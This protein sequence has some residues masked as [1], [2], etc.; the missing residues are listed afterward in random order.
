M[1]VSEWLN[2]NRPALARTAGWCAFASSAAIVI[3]IAP[4]QILLGVSLAALLLSRE[5]LRL[6]PIQLPLGLFLLG[7]LVAVALS[8]NPLA[9]F[10]QIKK[11]YVF[12]QLLVAFTLLQGAKIARWLVL[13]WAGCGAASALL[14]VFQF[15]WKL[16]YIHVHSEEFY[17]GYLSRRITGFMG[18]WYTFS[19]EEMLVLLMVGSFLLFSPM[20]RRRIWLWG[21][22]A[23][24]M[25]IGIL[26][27]QTRAVWVAT[28]AGAVYLLLCWRP[29][30]ALAIPVVV[31]IIL[32]AA[33]GWFRVRAFSIVYPT[34][35]DS[36]R[37]RLIL[38]R[39]GWEMVKAHPWFGLGPEMPRI[40]FMDYLPA[41]IPRPLPPG[42]TIHL[43]NIY[44]EYAAERGI[45]V[46]LIFLWLMGKILWDF[47]RGVR[48]LP[49]GRGDRRFLLH[50]GIAVILSLLL[51]GMTDYNLGDSEDLTIFL[52]VVALGY[53]ALAKRLE[54][55]A[56]AWAQPVEKW[57][58]G[59][60]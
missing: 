29:K 3:G 40:Q 48:A 9:G 2:S 55:D 33:P 32:V 14:G 10:P 31:A 36:N 21:A 27:A 17:S 12:S 22:L 15:A 6:P 4:S 53:N 49:P 39:T 34:V 58:A 26:L 44:L 13:T 45:P 51:E 57:L 42:S 59:H 5:K 43:H 54:T 20:A 52:V 19:V 23:M 50:G 8:S 30:A 28:I 11:I 24:A 60:R 7:T 25:G 46:L 18:H 37:F 38:M 1:R 41:D 56:P 16:Y 35:D 47:W